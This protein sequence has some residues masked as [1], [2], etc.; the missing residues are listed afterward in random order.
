MRNEM[1]DFR[2]RGHLPKAQFSCK[3]TV[4]PALRLKAANCIFQTSL[5][6]AVFPTL[7]NSAPT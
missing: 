5:F 6:T 2:K 4:Y 7:P 1:A 3:K